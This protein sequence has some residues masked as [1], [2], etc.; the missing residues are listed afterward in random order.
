M[1]KSYKEYQGFKVG[2]IINIDKI[3]NIDGIVFLIRESTYKP[4]L[5]RGLGE[6]R[7]ICDTGYPFWSYIKDD[8]YFVIMGEIPNEWESFDDAQM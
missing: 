8:D 6:I 2:D 4:L 1:L 3:W 5:I 7:F